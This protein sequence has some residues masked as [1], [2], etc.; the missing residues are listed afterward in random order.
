MSL[1][2]ANRGAAV[3]VPVAACLRFTALSRRFLG[4][5]LSFP[6]LCLRFLGLCLG[7]QGLT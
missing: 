6:G 4:I 2:P 1:S 5:C 3:A 7:F